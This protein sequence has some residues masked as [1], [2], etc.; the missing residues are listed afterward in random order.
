VR[1]DY[2]I[3][4][5]YAICFQGFDI[6]LSKVQSTLLP[7]AKRTVNRL[8][9]ETDVSI[10]YCPNGTKVL[11]KDLIKVRRGEVRWGEVRGGEAR[12]GEVSLG[13]V[14][15]NKVWVGCD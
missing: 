3:L 4:W 11:V 6:A 2:P 7:A 15:L 1:W 14:W 10:A 13:K 9:S 12:W 5:S 8:V